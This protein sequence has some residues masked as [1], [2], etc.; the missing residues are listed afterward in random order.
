MRFFIGLFS[1]TI[2]DVVQE[3]VLRRADI[4]DQNSESDT[5][6]QV[7]HRFGTRNHSRFVTAPESTSFLK[8]ISW[9]RASYYELER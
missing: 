9:V 6:L 8:A 5:P 3:L 4:N 7:A 2:E 1:N